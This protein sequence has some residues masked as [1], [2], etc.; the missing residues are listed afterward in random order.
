VAAN[1][2]L[3]ETV[4]VPGANL[5]LPPGTAGALLDADGAALVLHA[6]A[7]DHVTD[8]SGNSGGRIACA[9]IQPNPE[10]RRG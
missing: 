10:I 1:G 7:D 8:P 4:T 2:A 3:G 5:L 9:V 6:Q